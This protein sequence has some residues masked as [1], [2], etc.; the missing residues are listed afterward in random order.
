MT[1][2]CPMYSNDKYKIGSSDI[3]DDFTKHVGKY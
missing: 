1:S 2:T 3:T